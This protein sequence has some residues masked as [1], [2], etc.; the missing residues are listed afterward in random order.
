M[1]S[2]SVVEIMQR[3]VDVEREGADFYRKLAGE[4]SI[5]AVK[6]I[7]LGFVTDEV[8]HQK[9]FAALAKTM[10]GVVIESSLDILEVMNLAATKLQ[11]AMKGSQFV[12]M[13]EVNL[14][15]AIK[16]GIHNEEEAIKIYSSLL[17]VAHAEFNA[18]IKK[19][20]AEERSHL[21]ALENMKER[22]LG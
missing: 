9:D 18:V 14:S 12:D 1:Y 21:S 16:I 20:I 15:Q 2:Q 3:A 17:G 6:N 11:H 8:K 22:R 19:I 10:K 4:V 7:F 5:D 13:S